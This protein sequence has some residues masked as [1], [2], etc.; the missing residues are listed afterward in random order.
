MRITVLCINHS[1]GD[2]RVVLRQ[3]TSL[4]AAGHEV[5]VLGRGEEGRLPAPVPRL[6]LISLLPLI[7]KPTLGNKLARVRV[8]VRA[9]RA[10]LEDPP[11]VLAAHEPDS[12]WLALRL[13]R[14]LGAPVHFDVHEYFDELV[15]ARLPGALAPAGRRFMEGGLRSLARRAGCVT[16][17]TPRMVEQFRTLA[18]GRRVEILYNS[19]PIAYFPGCRQDVEGP[20][21]LCH[22]G[23]LHPS[24]GM[25]QLLEAVA[26]ARQQVPLRLLIVGKVRPEAQAE[27]DQLIQRLAIGDVVTVTGW[28]PYQEVGKVDARA[29]I[30]LVT[31]QPTG[32]NSGGLSN[33]LFSYMASGHA[34]IVPAGSAT[35]QL[36]RQ[37]DC[38]VPV[39][40]TNPADIAAAVV[41]LSQDHAWRRSLGRNAR[42]AVE[43]HLGWHRME[44]KLRDIYAELERS[45]SAPTR[46]GA[47]SPA[48]H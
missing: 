48:A 2:E 7:R 34:V 32:N 38:G 43:D 20:I 40:T 16:V 14:R 31:M 4:A 41:R 27:F 42:R 9:R 19:P 23:W 39:D 46:R 24:Y 18:P 17:V 45:R 6:K 37:Y 26:L 10:V 13:G 21:H 22:E 47:D 5:V 25:R 35:E 8:L 3:A 28:L 44:E 1:L 33:K 36:T 12:A 29:Q 11:D 30:G 15:A